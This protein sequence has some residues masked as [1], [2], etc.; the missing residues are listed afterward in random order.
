MRDIYS[1]ASKVVIYL[2]DAPD[3]EL[4]HQFLV[5]FV[6]YTELTFGSRQTML[7][8]E[9]LFPSLN[10]LADRASRQALLLRDAFVRILTHDYWARTWVIQEIICGKQASILCGGHYV[11]W[12]LFSAAVYHLK[13]DEGM[14]NML[15]DTC[16]EAR[17]SVVHSAISCVF[18]IWLL[19][20]TLAEGTM[21]H[22]ANILL[23]TGYSQAS[24]PQDKVL[25]LL[26]LSSDAEHP[27][28]QPNHELAVQQVYQNVTSQS[29]EQGSFA[30][31]SIA[32]L[33]NRKL[34]NSIIPD[35]PSWVPD[36]TSPGLLPSL[37][38][39]SWPYRARGASKEAKVVTDIEF[40]PGSPNGLAVQ[41]IVI[42]R[43]AFISTHHVQPYHWK[44]ISL[45]DRRSTTDWLSP[46]AIEDPIHYV[47]NQLRP[48]SDF[49]HEIWDMVETHCHEPYL[50]PNRVTITRPEALWR[51]VVGN[52][53]MGDEITHPASE[54]LGKEYHVFQSMCQALTRG[55]FVSRIKELQES[56]EDWKSFHH[57]ISHMRKST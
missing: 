14:L 37:D 19:Q 28:L 52:M 42:G 56:Q 15:L 18:S 16:D 24:R 46:T 23:N 7:V 41:G 22:L 27:D 51:T 12:E 50:F 29:L 34:Y 45:R 2:G 17:S 44:D 3:A 26:G 21:L 33:A 36:F 57:V 6:Q 10:P 40:D 4:A 8:F 31:S 35:L 25:A 43:I 20:K 49:R 55:D 53:M 11:D 5:R 54:E 30:L 1:G 9:T 32:G 13:S 47:G 38:H 39:P 48:E